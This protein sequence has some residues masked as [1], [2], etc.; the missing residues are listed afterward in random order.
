MSEVRIRARDR[1]VAIDIRV[2]MGNGPATITGGLGGYEVVERHDNVGVTDWS[3]QQPITQDVPLLL[4]GYEAGRSVEREWNTIKRL[5]LRSS[6]DRRP[7]VFTVE[8]PIEFPHKRWVL[9]DNG[10]TPV[11]E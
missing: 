4:N 2:P 6:A 10:I 8:G 1:E 5:G 11:A 7:P 9:P 3:K